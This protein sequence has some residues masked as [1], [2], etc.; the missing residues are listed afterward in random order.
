MSVFIA[1]L[2]LVY[3]ANAQARKDNILVSNAIKSRI[4]LSISGFEDHTKTKDVDEAAL[5][6]LQQQKRFISDHDMVKSLSKREFKETKK[7][8][9]I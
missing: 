5:S 4:R 6:S 7:T 8:L 3:K 1:T 2:E 9:L